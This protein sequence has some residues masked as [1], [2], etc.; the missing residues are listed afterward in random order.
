MSWGSY[1]LATAIG[2]SPLGFYFA[3]AGALPFW[4]QILAVG[5]ALAL[6]AFGF[7]RYGGQRE[8]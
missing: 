2:V 8:S 6:A 3:Y 1:V 5:I 4:Y 7:I